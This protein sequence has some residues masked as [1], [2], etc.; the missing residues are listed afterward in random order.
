MPAKR[1]LR[2]GLN[3]A[4]IGGAQDETRPIRRILFADPALLAA[5]CCHAQKISAKPI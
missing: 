2:R 4:R 5:W 1:K 3:P